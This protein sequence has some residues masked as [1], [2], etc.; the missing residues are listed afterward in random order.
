MQLAFGCISGIAGTAL[1]S[2]F[3]LAASIISGFNFRIP[4]ILGTLITFNTRRSGMPSQSLSTRLWGYALHYLIGIGFAL[5]Y[6]QLV[7]T[8]INQTYTTA[9]V[10]GGVA[11]MLAAGAWHLLL[12]VHPLT[13]V[14]NLS[15]YLI[16]IFIAHLVFATGM[17]LTLC[18][19]NLPFIGID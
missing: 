9:L 10:F 13:P 4:V 7:S 12:R 1:M 3:M 2:T 15:A 11:G 18:V 8:R 19:L 5:I 16:L 14:L 6:Q 17:F